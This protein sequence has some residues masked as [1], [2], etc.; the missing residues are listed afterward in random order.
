MEK[1]GAAMVCSCVRKACVAEKEECCVQKK[2]PLSAD[3]EESAVCIQTMIA[4]SSPS[5]GLFGQD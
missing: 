4:S 3:K 1:N 2:C 5:E